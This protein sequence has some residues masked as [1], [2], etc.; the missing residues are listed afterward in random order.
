MKYK[1]LIIMGALIFPMYSSVSQVVW[2]DCQPAVRSFIDGEY[3][4]WNG[5][6]IYELDNGQIWKQAVYHYH[7]HYAYHPKVLVFADTLGCRM[8][9]SGDDDDGVL[10]RKI[11]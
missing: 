4:G 7:Y 1:L 11:R 9:V 5:D 6:T 8:V 2:S 10:V 3:N